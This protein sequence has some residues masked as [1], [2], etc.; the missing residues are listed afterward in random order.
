MISVT[1]VAPGFTTSPASAARTSTTPSIGAVTSVYASRTF[2]RS[3]L[4]AGRRELA[5]RGLERRAAHGDL[6][7]VCLRER[8][9]GLRRLDLLVAGLGRCA[10]GLVGGPR[11][12][13]RL[14]GV[15][16]A[17]AHAL[18]PV[19]LEPRLLEI[20]VACCRLR[21]THREVRVGLVNLLACLHLEQLELRDGLV[22]GGRRRVLGVLVV[23]EVGLGVLGL[24]TREHLALLDRVA[25]ADHE[26]AQM[27]LG[28]RA[29]PDLVGR[30]DAGQHERRRLVGHEMEDHARSEQDDDR[31]DEEHAT[32][33]R[34]RR[35]PG[36]VLG[37][38]PAASEGLANCAP[39]SAR[40]GC[41]RRKGARACSGRAV[42]CSVHS[43]LKRA[44]GVRARTLSSQAVVQ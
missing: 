11:L 13:E 37:S 29:D 8:E 7:L 9:R 21:A 32:A 35:L 6:L 43:L 44:R 10:R 5:T 4:R 31:D 25:G 1:I 20:R 15:E 16:L 26:V 19:E 36:V 30:D 22:D 33:F 41:D 14:L 42:I 34:L 27:P 38:A 12:V 28:H 23:R 39:K 2:A 40:P 24:D 3:R 17:L 18:L